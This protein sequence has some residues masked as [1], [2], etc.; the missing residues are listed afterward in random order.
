MVFN[1][2][3]TTMEAEDKKVF[4]RK[5]SSNQKF[6]TQSN[7]Q[8]AFSFFDI[9]VSKNFFS[10]HP[11]PGSCC[12]M[13]ACVL[14]HFSRIQ[15]FV[16]LWTVAYQSPLSMGF[17]RQEYWSGLPCFPPGDLPDPGIEPAYLKSPALQDM[18]HKNKG[19]NQEWGRHGNQKKRKTKRSLILKEEKPD[20]YTLY[21]SFPGDPRGKEPACQGRRHKRHGFD[22]WVRKIPWRRAWKP[23]P[24]FLPEESRGQRSLAVHR[25]SKSQTW[26]KWLTTHA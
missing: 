12:R 22:T 3:T 11:F 26:L 20:M 10:T 25:V 5:I 9:G 18:L 4:W 15:F 21:V 19:V 14:S 2:L 24:V 17:S 13:R 8:S 16:T 1:F 7:K 6:C 23:T